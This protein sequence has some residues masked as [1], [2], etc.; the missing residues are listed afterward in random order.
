LEPLELF[1]LSR[2][3]RSIHVVIQAYIHRAFDIR[4]LL[5]PY[6]S[7]VS[8]F[9][10]LQARTGLLISGS[11]AVQF[12]ARIAYPESDLDLY[13]EHRWYPVVVDFLRADGYVFVP[14]ERTSPEESVRAALSL[15]NAC[16]SWPCFTVLVF[17]RGKRTIELAVSDVAPLDVI[18]QTYHS[19][20]VLNVI[21]HA[22]AY[23][24]FPRATFM[25]R[26]MLVFHHPGTPNERDEIEALE[27]YIR[28]GWRAVEHT[29]VGGGNREYTARV[30]WVGDDLTWRVQLAPELSH[31]T[32]DAL[33]HRRFF[34]CTS[35]D[36]VGRKLRSVA[37]L[38]SST[39]SW[40]APV[41]SLARRVFRS[42]MPLLLVSRL[43][44]VAVF[45][46]NAYLQWRSTR[47]REMQR[48]STKYSPRD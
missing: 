34:V 31:L 9:R 1:I 41:A 35:V 27:K 43:R 22:A 48:D 12:F 5:T 26:E 4:R 3:S 14:S 45:W 47:I 16:T 24:L 36:G 28:R 39:A 37:L 42:S 8:A 19:S 18:L 21:S 17:V 29:Q 10:A 15:K 11:V 2:T 23:S 38:S 44:N 30:R 6:F 20:C 32:S 25:H 46:F 7:S 13:V 40:L 33:A